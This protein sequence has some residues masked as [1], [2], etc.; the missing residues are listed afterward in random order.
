MLA[1]RSRAST[2]RCRLLDDPVAETECD[3]VA[4]GQLPHASRP[5]PR[6]TGLL[7][8]LADVHLRESD[9]DADDL[10]VGN[11]GRGRLPVAFADDDLHGL[12]ALLELTRF[13]GR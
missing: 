8:P 10:V 5:V 7:H 11:A 6:P 13:R 1:T 9:A 4:I 3:R 12:E 2:G